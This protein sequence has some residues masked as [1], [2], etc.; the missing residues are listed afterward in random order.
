V[1]EKKPEALRDF[2]AEASV[3]MYL[4]L[5]VWRALSH[6]LKQGVGFETPLPVRD[7]KAWFLCPRSALCSRYL[8]PPV[9]HR[10][11]GFGTGFVDASAHSNVILRRRHYPCPQI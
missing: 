11:A 8:F 10:L 3:Y 5:I 9:I 7:G 2:R 6:D 4:A 1:F